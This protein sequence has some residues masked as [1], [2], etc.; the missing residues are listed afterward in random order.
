MQAPD[1]QD[2]EQTAAGGQWH[3]EHRPD[4][5]LPEDRVDHR[6]RPDVV[7]HDRRP[8]RR[9]PPGEAGPDRHPHPLLDLLLEAPRRPRH[10]V[11]APTVEEQDGGHVGAD[12]VAD[13]VEEVVERI[14][15]RMVMRSNG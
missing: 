13:V 8:R 4:A 10:E 5:L 14:A 11:G 9:D 6:R 1:V 2:A 3:A 7:E 12:P 15:R